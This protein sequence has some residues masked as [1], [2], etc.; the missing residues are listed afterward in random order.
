MN[1]LS[2]WA[3]IA[4]IVLVSI[5]K[6]G[7]GIFTAIN[8]SL[9]FWTSIVSNMIG[10]GI[11]VFMFTYLGSFIKKIYIKF[12]YKNKKPIIFNKWNRFLIRFRRNFGLIGIAILSPII[13]TIPVGVIL[14]LQITDNKVKIFFYIFSGCLIWSWIFFLIH[15]FFNIK[16]F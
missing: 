1:Y 6:Y 15:H 13:L 3:Q 9:G 7:I 2:D 4:I 11:G 10:G 14:S 8:S 5:F 16:I 12:R